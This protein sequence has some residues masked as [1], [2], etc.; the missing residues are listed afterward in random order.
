[1]LK[2]L[3]IFSLI[4]ATGACTT[5]SYLSGQ[6]SNAY[7]KEFVLSAETVTVIGI[8]DDD[9]TIP[10]AVSAALSNGGDAPAATLLAILS[11]SDVACEDYMSGMVTSSNTVISILGIS[12]LA[13]SGAASLTSPTRSANLLSG[14]ATFAGGT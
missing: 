11:S 7:Q 8:G 9:M 10:T 5:S 13:L 6:K 1:M 2:K 4:L 3:S 14:V 12:N